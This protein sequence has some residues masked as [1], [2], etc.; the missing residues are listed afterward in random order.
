MNTSTLLRHP[1]TG[2]DYSVPAFYRKPR[3]ARGEVG[4]QPVYPIGGG[5]EDGGGDGETGGGGGDA[6]KVA[7]DAAAETE[8]TKTAEAE[9]AKKAAESKTSKTGDEA[10]DVASLPDWAQKLISKERGDAAKSRATKDKAAED[11]AQA[12]AQKIGLAL[13][14]VKGEEKIDPAKLAADLTDAQTETRDLKIERAVDKTARK[15]GADEDL[16]A[17][18]LAHKGLLKDLDP[19]SNDFASKL[20]KLVK[21]ELVANPKLRAAQAAGKGGSEFTG[22]SGEGAGKAKTLEEAITKKMAG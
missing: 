11:A 4:P 21:D 16:L 1:L 8:A 2:T 20:D 18:V 13:G 9:A 5:A 19:A 22:G 3:L 12:V 17:A 6:A 7:A 10:K 15:Q 14:L